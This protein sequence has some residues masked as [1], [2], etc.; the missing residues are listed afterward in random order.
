MNKQEP[1]DLYRKANE[2]LLPILNYARY[3]DPYTVDGD[4][5]LGRPFSEVEE[6]VSFLK[7]ESDAGYRPAQVMLAECLYRGY[8]VK[9]DHD[10]ARKLFLEASIAEDPIAQFFLAQMYERG[11]AGSPCDYTQ[12]LE[13]Y[14]KSASAGNLMAMVGLGSLYDQGHGVVKDEVEALKWY[15]KAAGL[16][17]TNAQCELGRKYKNGY[18]V[19][20]NE[21]E[22]LK[23]YLKAAEFHPYAQYWVGEMYAEGRGVDKNEAEALKWYL[24]SAE[25][26]VE[27]Q[28]HVAEMYDYGHGVGKNDAEALKWYLKAAEYHSGAQLRMGEI[29]EYGLFGVKRDYDKAKDWYMEAADHGDETAQTIVEC[30]RLDVYSFGVRNELE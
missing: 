29:Y 1:S 6:A 8:G 21:A 18:G 17:D 13:L 22:A 15:L 9:Q 3:L 4:W 24:R 30:I 5:F 14:R 23:W 26:D 20:K 19:E 27:S 12:A 2:I 25:Y 7:A 16:G 11:I 10:A 28:F